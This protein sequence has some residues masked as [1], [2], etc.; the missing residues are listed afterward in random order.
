MS[1]EQGYTHEQKK[2]DVK[3]LHE[4]GYAQELTRRMGAFQNFAISF[5]IICIVAGGIT[6]F[7]AALSSGGGAAIGIIWPLG[8]LFALI[9]AAAMGQIASA[10]P[11]AGGIYHWSSLLG[12]RGYGW[13]GAWFNLLGLIFVVASVNFGLYNLFRDLFLAQVLGWDVAPWTST[14]DFSEGWWRQTGFIVTVTIVQAII[15]HYFLRLTTVLTDFSGYLIL[16]TTVLLTIALLAFMGHSP[17]FSRLTSYTNFTGETGGNVWPAYAM[18]M[19]AIL[20][21]GLLHAVYTI[22]GFD[23][24]AHTS[25]ETRNAPVE[26]PKGMIRSVFWSFLFGYFMVCAFVLA[27]PDQTDAS[28]KVV[29]G[30]S[31]GAAQGW[32]SFNWLMANSPMP[33][34]LRALLIIGIVVSNFLCALAGLTSM[35]RMMYAFARDGGLPASGVLRSVS[36]TTRT[37]GPA[38]WAGG[39]LAVL[40]TLYGDAFIVLSTGCAVFLY[41]SYLMPVAAAMLSEMGGHWKHKGPFNLGG[42]SIPVALLAI[43]GCAVLITVGV[44]PPQ[45]KVGYLIVIGLLAMAGLW[46][47][48]E[49]NRIVSLIFSALTA[50]AV[51]FLWGTVEGSENATLYAGCVL[52]AMVVLSLAL[53]GKRFAGPPIGE[54]IKRRQAEIAAEEARVGERI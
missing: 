33:Q 47:S 16:A 40:A 4:M 53:Y 1:A 18:P 19:F 43:I 51:W 49:S 11:T 36:P 54:E 21:L 27:L 37:P 25:E 12:G 7:P 8:S 14:G 30:V 31:A 17:D 39:V 10:Y 29:D 24:S 13:A 9:V 48:M 2:T 15:N 50:A 38:I 52:A 23:A 44:V 42:A 32:A 35:S 22:T 6:A 5:A 26:V 46:A 34:F 28:G 3:I 45:Q 41:I 20:G